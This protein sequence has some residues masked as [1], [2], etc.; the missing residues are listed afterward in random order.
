M[1][2]WHDWHTPYTDDTSAL[3]RR[4]RLVQRH[5]GDWLNER[6]ESSLRVVSVCAGQG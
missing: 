2:D 1:K 3:S 4:L 5:I 6:P